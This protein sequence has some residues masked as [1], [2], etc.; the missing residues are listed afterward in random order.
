L[1]SVPV[2]HATTPDILDT[3]KVEISIG[4]QEKELNKAQQEAWD[5]FKQTDAYKN[6]LPELKKRLV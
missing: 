1:F 2:T 3:Q 6:M 5:F 4:N